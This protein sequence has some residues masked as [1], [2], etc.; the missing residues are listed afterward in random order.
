MGTF[1]FFSFDPVTIGGTL[2]NTLI[3]WLIFKRLLFDKVNAILQQRNDDIAKSYADA[4]AAV[5]DADANKRLY[6]EKLQDAK[7]ES[8]EIVKAATKK[9]QVR[10]EEIIAE[11]KND[12]RM[13]HAKA[14]ADMEKEKKQTVNA[15]KDDISVLVVSVAEKVVKKEIDAKTHQKLIDDAISELE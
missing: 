4:D 14:Q 15:I 9:A 12:A 7:T 8:A 1:D 10:S 2:V 11:A 3:I 13:A 6:E 5:K